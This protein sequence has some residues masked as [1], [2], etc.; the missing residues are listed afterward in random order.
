MEELK[1]KWGKIYKAVVFGET[2]LY[3]ALRI[4]EFR[5]VSLIDEPEDKELAILRLGVLSP[6]IASLDDLLSGVAEILI[7]LVSRVTDISED[8][9]SQKVSEARDNLGITDN[10]LSLEVEIIRNLNYTPDRVKGMTLDEF[11]EALA[12]AEAVAGKPLL[13]TGK[14]E[15]PAA[16]REDTS[17]EEVADPRDPNQMEEVANRSAMRLAQNYARGRRIRGRDRR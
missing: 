1:K 16:I 9:L 2:Y 4:G 17:L 3:R 12:M 11:A 13:S 14:E 7:G 15:R 8:T 10:V 5:E 6:K